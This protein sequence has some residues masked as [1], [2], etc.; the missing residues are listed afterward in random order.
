MAK[1]KVIHDQVNFKALDVHSDVLSQGFLAHSYGLAVIFGLDS[2]PD[3]LG[4]AMYQLRRLLKP[5]AYLLF[6]QSFDSQRS[7]SAGLGPPLSISEF[8]S[9][10]SK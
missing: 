7:L 10:S 5:G 6:S 2:V 3:I 1:T 4:T 8:E 9:N